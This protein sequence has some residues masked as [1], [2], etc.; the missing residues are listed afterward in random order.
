MPPKKKSKGDDYLAWIDNEVELLF[1]STRE[2]KIKKAYEG[3]EWESVK[4]KYFK[5]ALRR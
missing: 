5:F 2:F 1:G 4:D 3:V